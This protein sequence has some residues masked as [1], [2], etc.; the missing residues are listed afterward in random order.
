MPQSRMCPEKIIEIR[1]ATV[2]RGD[3]KVFMDLS[4]DIVQ[5]Q[6]TVIL[7][8]NGAGKTTLLK[9]LTREIY[10][11]RNDGASVRILGKDKWDVWDLRSGIGIVSQDLQQNYAGTVCGIDV[12]LSGYYSSIGVYGHQSFDREKREHAK[13]IIERLGVATLRDHRFARM[14]TGEQRRFL[15]GRALV[16]APHTLILD[17]P[18]TGLDLTATFH[19]LRLVRRLMREGKT[20][21]L[22]TH[23]IHEIPPEVTEIILLKG[24]KVLAQG[25]KHEL[26]TDDRLTDLF[27]TPVKLVSDGGYYQALP[28]KEQD[29][30]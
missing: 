9:L 22:V 12:V 14:S 11:V 15:L 29:S 18:T 19:Y 26:L 13:E 27:D 28:G 5:G 10:P 1:N 17:E 21:I 30:P 6:N 16:N 8:P 7:G 24:G 3:T 23:H 4:L 25:A 2:F 20:I